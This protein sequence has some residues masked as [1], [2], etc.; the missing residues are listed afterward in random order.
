MP[1]IKQEQ[2]NFLD[3]SIDKLVDKLKLGGYK[4]GEINYTITR[5]L[6]ASWRDKPSYTTAN[7]LIGILECA[8]LEFY[9]E[10]VALYENVKRLENGDVK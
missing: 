1:Y 7:E 2:R 10:H 6:L 9:R 4:P 8:K 3:L 5:L